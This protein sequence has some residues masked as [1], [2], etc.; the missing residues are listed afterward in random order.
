MIA[1]GQSYNKL[2]SFLIETLFKYIS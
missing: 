2:N 1:D